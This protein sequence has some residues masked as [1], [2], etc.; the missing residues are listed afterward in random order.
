VRNLPQ[1]LGHAVR[2]QTGLTEPNIRQILADLHAGAAQPRVPRRSAI[3]SRKS[4]GVSREKVL[5]ARRERVR[6]AGRHDV[7][8]EQAEKGK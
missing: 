1:S 8:R 3:P 5:E 2:Q 7:R 6:W 4:S